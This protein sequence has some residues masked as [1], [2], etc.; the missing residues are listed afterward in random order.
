MGLLLHGEKLAK[1]ESK[2]IHMAA[3]D[4][5]LLE[6]SELYKLISEDPAL[7]ARLKEESRIKHL[8]PSSSA[9]VPSN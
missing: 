6:M 1:A 3:E 7:F 9:L 5:S 2:L 4:P 8:S